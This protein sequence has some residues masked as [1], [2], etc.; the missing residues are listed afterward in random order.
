[1]RSV[2]GMPAILATIALTCFAA[3][4]R[5]EVDADSTIRYL[6]ACQKPNGAFGPADQ[7]HSDLAWNYPAVHAL[8]LLGA[9]V[10]RAKDCLANGQWAA[11]REKDAHRT[12][13]HW[14]LYQK[15]H[16][17]RL[18]A[19]RIPGAAIDVFPGQRQG[20]DRIELGGR[21]RFEY[22]DREGKYYGPYGVGVFY[23]VPTLWYMVSALT[24]L[25]GTIVNAEVAEAFLDARQVEEGGFV[26]AYRL[27]PPPTESDAHLIITCHAVTTYHALGLPVPDAEACARWIRSCQTP[28]GGFRWSASR[29]DFSNQPDAW[30]T[31][32]AVRALKVLGSQPER[33][34]ACIDWLNALQNPDGGFGDRPGWNSRLYSTYYA[35]HAL[36]LLTGD[37]KTAI[38]RKT[39]SRPALVIPEGKYSIYQAHL[40]A[41]AVAG[42]SQR[43]MVEQVRRMRLHLIGAKTTDVSEARR[44][45]EA[46]GYALEVVA[47]PEI[48]PH[49]LHWL[50]GHPADHVSNWLIPPDLSEHDQNV[51]SAADAAGKR[52][53][54]WSR[55]KHEVIGPVRAVGTLFY[56]ELDYSMVNSY[57]VYDDGLEGRPGFNAIIAALGWPAW[58]WV[59]HFPYRERWIGKLPA[60]ADGDAHGDVAKWRDRLEKQRILYIAQR[61]DLRHFLDA[62]RRGRSVCVIRDRSLS[63]GA[64][65]Y[66]SSAAVDYVKKHRDEWQW[67]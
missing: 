52:G 29:D 6:L 61:H 12:N 65:Y 40:K 39:V 1:M 15:A 11:F 23:D 45:V 41:P 14:D 34:D 56:P 10:P 42:E 53:L 64:V 28:A 8:V 66:G 5:E 25:D 17:N 58:D 36:E 54:P 20:D 51:F 31:W 32:A 27:E 16:L 37:A 24:T 46:Q 38:R 48:Y 55:F 67:W 62:L 21:W 13:L 44:H 4:I 22:R 30:Y 9:E 2:M 49:R 33:V 7:E 57:M 50:G 60:V 35:V 3:E 26:D 18:L 59:R 63:E 19:G 43:A 47:C